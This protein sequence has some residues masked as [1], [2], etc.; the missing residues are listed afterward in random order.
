MTV[1]AGGGRNMLTEA[2]LSAASIGVNAPKLVAVTTLTSLDQNDLNELGIQR[3]L[4]EHT[5]ALGK[6]AIDCGIDGL[7][8][9]PLEVANFRTTLGEKPV[10]VTPGIRPAG[11]DIGDQ[12]RVATPASAVKDGSSFLVVG[13]PILSADNPAEAAAEIIRQMS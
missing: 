4:A 11:G 3:D 6:L 5:A 12:K 9:S 8:C 10:L 13:R 1:H 7:V 2:A